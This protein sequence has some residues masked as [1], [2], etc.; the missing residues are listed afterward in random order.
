M[1]V[2]T[3]RGAWQDWLYE[4]EVINMAT[5][6]NQ[7]FRN[8]KAHHLT[9]DNLVPDTSYKFRVRATSDGGGQGPWSEYFQS[10]TL[11]DGEYAGMP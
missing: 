5:S 2:C 6:H 4:A 1:C 8:M 3:G 7:S 9:V 11:K 10:V